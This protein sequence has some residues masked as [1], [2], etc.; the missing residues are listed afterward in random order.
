MPPR[1]RRRSPGA[2]HDAAVLDHGG[3]PAL[4]QHRDVRDRV[5][6]G[7][8]EVARAPAAMTPSS[9]SR[10]SRVAANRGGAAD[11]VDGRDGPG[12]DGELLR[13]VTVHPAE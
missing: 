13:L 9:P 12:A 11:D 10:W 3:E 8:D 4:G 1:S 7:D 5:V 2:R 6:L